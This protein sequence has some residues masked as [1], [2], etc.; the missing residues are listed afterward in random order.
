MSRRRVGTRPDPPPRAACAE[1]PPAKARSGVLRKPTSAKPLLANHSRICGV[2]SM[3][4]VPRVHTTV[5]PATSSGSAATVRRTSSSEML[6]NTPQTSSTSARGEGL[7][8]LEGSRVGHDDLHPVETQL[9]RRPAGTF[10]Q[11]GV[12]LDQRRGV[13][14]K[15]GLGQDGEDVSALTRTQQ[16][17]AAMTQRSVTLQVPA[18][19]VLPSPRH[20]GPV[21]GE[22][23]KGRSWV[24]QVQLRA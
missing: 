20:E 4:S 13:T 6:P 2:R 10:R 14:R 17:G 12:D 22:Q 5:P 15:A 3:S 24:S 8:G 7:V 18:A 1:H 11:T 9:G 23:A 16:R 19:P 21:G